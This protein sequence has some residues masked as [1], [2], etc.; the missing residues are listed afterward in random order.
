VPSFII[1]EQFALLVN[2]V[3][4][5]TC[6]FKE[7]SRKMAVLQELKKCLQIYFAL[8]RNKKKQ[9]HIDPDCLRSPG[10]KNYIGERIKI[11][12]YTNFTQLYRLTLVLSAN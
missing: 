12:V 5:V 6:I 10:S 9:I 2:I 1:H 7:I 4:K 3:A 8:S 11:V